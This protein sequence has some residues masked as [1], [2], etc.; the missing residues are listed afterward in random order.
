MNKRIYYIVVVL[1][2][3]G[4]SCIAPKKYNEQLAENVRMQGEITQLESDLEAAN[5]KISKLN[6][7]LSSLKKS[8]KATKEDLEATTASLENLQT[9]HEKLQT[10][11]DNVL[12]NA[13]KLNRDLAAQQERLLTMESDLETAKKQNDQL[14]LDLNERERK[15][16]ELEKILA[17]KDSA[18]QALKK[19]VTDAL[20]NF[21]EKD[22]T[23]EVRNGKVYVSLAEQLLFKSG[24]T[25]VD[26]KGR[27]A[28]QQLAAALKDSNDIHVMV[29]GHTDNVPISR[30]SQY[31]NDNWD[32]SVMRATTIVRILTNYGVAPN[33]ITASGKGEFSPLT[34]NSSAE[35]KQKNRRTEI[36]LTPN[37]DE[38]FKI[39]ES[40]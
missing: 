27:R 20:L 11:Y 21:G 29:E 1:T 14:A 16:A 35:N 18:T 37:L 2:I 5:T 3:V 4:T 22:L 33:Q 28:L 32:L 25:S 24:S 40:N 6:E 9:E 8:N 30:T 15:V 36:I 12:K 39:L 10:L 13:G 7:E 17:D 26:E 34:D 31:M 38:L 19:R 23:V